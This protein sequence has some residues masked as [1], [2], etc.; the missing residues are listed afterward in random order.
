MANQYDGIIV[1]TDGSL[2]YDGHPVRQFITHVARMLNQ[3]R[4]ACAVT[5]VV[6]VKAHC[7][8]PLNVSRAIRVRNH[9]ARESLWQAAPQL[10][11]SCRLR[12]GTDVLLLIPC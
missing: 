1:A 4:V 7:A 10:I 2:K 11:K 12:D 9:L 3:L 5:R 6:N 8:E